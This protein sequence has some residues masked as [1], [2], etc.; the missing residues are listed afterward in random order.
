MLSGS[1]GRL[2]SLLREPSPGSADVEQ[3][4]GDYLALDP[5]RHQRLELAQAVARERLGDL[6]PEAL[7]LPE[8]GL[9]QLAERVAEAV[10]VNGPRRGP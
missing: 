5:R 2:V 4:A 3:V 8:L 10:S 6:R 7:V 9:P 1:R